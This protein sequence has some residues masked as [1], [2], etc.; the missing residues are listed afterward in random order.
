MLIYSVFIFGVFV[1][2]QNYQNFLIS[3]NNAPTI[4]ANQYQG[5]IN[6]S[7]EE[8]SFEDS[9]QSVPRI[10]FSMGYVSDFTNNQHYTIYPLEALLNN[11]GQIEL[12][13]NDKVKLEAT[14]P[15]NSNGYHTLWS[16]SNDKIVSVDDNG[17]VIAVGEGTAEV[18]F[19]A[20]C[21]SFNT[22]FIVQDLSLKQVVLSSNNA[23]LEPGEK[24][25]LRASCYPKNAIGDKTVVWFSENKDIATVENGIITAI[26]PGTTK[27]IAKAGDVISSCSV[28]VQ[29]KLNEIHLSCIESNMDINA[30]LDLDVFYAPENTSADKTVTWT[31]SDASVATVDKDGKVTTLSPGVAKITAQVGE[32]KATCVVR[33]NMLKM[34][35][36]F[37]TL[38]VGESVTLS[39]K[40]NILSKDIIWHSDN[41]SIA[42]VDELGVVTAVS[43]GSTMITAQI[44]KEILTCDVSVGEI[45][46]TEIDTESDAK[47]DFLD[48]QQMKIRRF[49]R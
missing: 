38:K 17:L 27:I 12:F 21:F 37:L 24:K 2:H 19:T 10:A 47:T 8:I 16:S 1:I 4:E 26:S 6:I 33:V 36:G 7:T 9:Q 31:S 29:R 40:N 44:D 22:T 30:S 13:V 20:G 3:Q 42:T 48:N 32:L 49:L 45:V 23:T 43:A 15:L 25:F 5:T 18:S 39:V 46:D 41:E 28:T 34:S 14:L 35:E 11:K